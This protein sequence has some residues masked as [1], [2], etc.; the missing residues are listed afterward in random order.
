VAAACSSS[1]APG[2]G[3]NT[4]PLPDG[5][6]PV[7]DIGG[8]VP[9]S[10]NE[11]SLSDEELGDL[12]MKEDERDLDS[13]G[14]VDTGT[15]P[16]D[17]PEG[18]VTEDEETF[19]DSEP[20]DPVWTADDIT[21]SA[22]DGQ[23]IIGTIS[24]AQTRAPGKMFG[25]GVDVQKATASP[26]YPM[27]VDK[28]KMG[29]YS[30]GAFRR[31]YYVQADQA[32]EYKNTDAWLAGGANLQPAMGLS[33]RKDRILTS[34]RLLRARF[35]RLLQKY[36]QVKQWG[37]TNEPELEIPRDDQWARE[38]VNYF[39]D[40]AQTLRR[41]LRKKLCSRDVRLLAGEFSYQSEVKS[42]PLWEKYGAEMFR[43]IKTA[44][45]QKGR[46]RALPKTWG[47]HPY[48]DTTWG[49]TS[50]TR[51]LSAFLGKLEKNPEGHVKKGA[52][53]LWLT[54]TGT[55]LEYGNARG[56]RCFPNVDGKADAQRKGAAAVYALAKLGRVDRVYWWQ[57][58]EAEDAWGGIWDS[59]M[60]D[61]TGTPRASFCALAGDAAGC[62]G[63]VSPKHCPP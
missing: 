27:L 52:L 40:G 9:D 10:V 53:R 11:E 7:V 22:N 35:W 18:E 20:V 6:S 13:D 43:N 2:T 60:I 34:H 49:V 23:P 51:A 25:L 62:G 63:K 5:G 14:D 24:Q 61:N 26:L 1:S 54:E 55:L 12:L 46:L 21:G 57:F 30:L 45:N 33:I 58:Q 39:I 41:C 47:F 42:K 17:E 50:G 31:V 4:E 16:A 29:A 38:A 8:G 48:R 19:V 36:K 56:T 3:A 44:S 32:G 37:V 59:A 15:E 28:W